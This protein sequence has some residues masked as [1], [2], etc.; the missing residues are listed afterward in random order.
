MKYDYK[1]GYEVMVMEYDPQKL[2][3]NKHGTYSI[4]CVFINNKVL[5][6]ISEHI[7]ERFNVRKL[8]PYR[9]I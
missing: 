2:D 3:T 6:Q 4:I 8:S 7:Q 5:V 1:V 9:E